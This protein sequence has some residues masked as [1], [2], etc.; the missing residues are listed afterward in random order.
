[1]APLSGNQMLSRTVTSRLLKQARSSS[2]DLVKKYLQAFGVV[3]IT[4][5]GAY[6]LP[7]AFDSQYTPEWEAFLK[8]AHPSGKIEDGESYLYLI[9]S[10][11]R[12]CRLIKVD[13]FSGTFSF[14]DP[15]TR[16][17]QLNIS[18]IKKRIEQNSINLLFKAI[19]NYLNR[20]YIGQ[21]LKQSAKR[22]AIV[23]ASN[24]I[25]KIVSTY[26]LVPRKQLDFLDDVLGNLNGVLYQKTLPVQLQSKTKLVGKTRT[27]ELL[28]KY[29]QIPLNTSLIGWLPLI[30]SPAFEISVMRA[31]N[32]RLVFKVIVAI[33][34][35]KND[36]IASTAKD[37]K[38]I[39]EKLKLFPA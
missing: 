33:G 16:S 15:T 23:K 4:G 20:F 21:Y 38:A 2:G 8:S 32:D 12:Y 22:C 19:H 30:R 24:G 39:W 29:E 3:D 1:M 26:A 27:V 36:H 37:K 7:P 25:V 18:N 35:M 28:P 34:N 13:P 5:S 11:V 14:K 6:Q 9:L 17:P 10:F 31:K